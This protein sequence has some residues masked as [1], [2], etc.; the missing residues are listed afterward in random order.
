MFRLEISLPRSLKL[1][2][3]LTREKEMLFFWVQLVP[4]SQRQ[5]LG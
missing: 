2:N 3:E 1:Q 4:E 5:L